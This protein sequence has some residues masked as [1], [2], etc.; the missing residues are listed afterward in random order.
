MTWTVGQ[1]SERHDDGGA[2]ADGAGGAGYGVLISRGR[3]WLASWWRWAPERVEW[4][5][6]GGSGALGEEGDETCSFRRG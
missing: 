5:L 2:D 3:W 6:W 1:R 4:V